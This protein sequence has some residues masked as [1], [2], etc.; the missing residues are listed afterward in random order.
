MKQPRAELTRCSGCKVQGQM[1][2]IDAA[3]IGMGRRNFM[4]TSTVQ[5][6]QCS[7]LA[8]RGMYSRPTPRLN[9]SD[10]LE[11]QTK[12]YSSF[13]QTATLAAKLRAHASSTEPFHRT[14]SEFRPTHLSPPHTQALHDCS[15]NTRD[16]TDRSLHSTSMRSPICAAAHATG[17]CASASSE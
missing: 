8:L 16:Q 12:L 17:T 2:N 4:N 11:E 10:S 5:P 6:A 13:R 9:D 15:M 3:S 14:D 7:P 1:I